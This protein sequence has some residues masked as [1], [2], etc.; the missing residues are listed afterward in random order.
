MGVA[1]RN[2]NDPSSLK[3]FDGFLMAA[4]DFESVAPIDI[5]L[6]SDYVWTTGQFGLM[7]QKMHENMGNLIAISLIFKWVI[8]SVG[9]SNLEFIS[10]Q[11]VL[12]YSPH[13]KLIGR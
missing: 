3:V 7:G 8:T 12:R 4:I 10:L 2:N 13:K 5:L 11:Q 9:D 1:K 6:G